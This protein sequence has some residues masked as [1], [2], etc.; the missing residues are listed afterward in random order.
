MRDRN[1]GRRGFTLIELLVVIAIIAILIGLLLPA[2]QKVRE[3]AARMSCTNN[4]KQLALASHNYES[5]YGYLPPGHN[6]N[7][8][9]GTLGYLLPYIEQGNIYNLIPQNALTLP[10]TSGAYYSTGGGWAAANNSVKTFLCPSDDAQNASPS[11]GTFANVSG[12][13]GGI[14]GGVWGGNPYPTLGRTNYAFSAGAT[15]EN[16]PSPYSNWVGPFTTNSKTAMTTIG[17]GTS[18]TI[19]LGETLGGIDTGGRD[20]VFS[21]MGTGGM[22]TAWGPLTPSGWTTYGSKHTGVVL[23]GWGDGS[24]RPVRK[25]SG[26]TDWWSTRW[27]HNMYA[28]GMNDG[29]VI[30]FSL[31]SN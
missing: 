19:F 31:F 26:T 9:I 14:G 24:V 15:G 1:T 20:Y 29:Q 3:A 2:V 28:S 8:L 18:N 5:A 4:I 16:S 25:I 13:G 12:S 27:Y 10:G 23:F 30:D 7:S 17:D 6:S 11:A 21:W 22:P